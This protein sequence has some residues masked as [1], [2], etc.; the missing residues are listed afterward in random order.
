MT[1][2]S[3]TATAFWPRPIFFVRDLAASLRYY[4]DVLGFEMKWAHG[5]DRPCI[6]QVDRDGIELILD[7][8]SD[9]PAAS[10]RSVIAMELHAYD[11]LGA[12][13]DELQAA[14]AR[15]T[16]AP[17]EVHWAEKTM[18]MDVEDLDGNVL[19]FWGNVASNPS[20]DP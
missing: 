12:L 3:R 4:C 5:D 8:D 14:G 16:A 10:P 2:P 1:D 18:Q 9:L 7:Q 6:A 19:I 11:Q 17:F 20:K 13:H 15:V